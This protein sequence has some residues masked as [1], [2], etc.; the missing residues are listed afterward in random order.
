MVRPTIDEQLHALQR[1]LSEVV[2]PE[3]TAKYPSDI[4]QSVIANL[5]EL[6]ANWSRWVGFL[7][8]DNEHLAEV[9]EQAR[10]K[11]SGALSQQIGAALASAP[12]DPYDYGAV[13]RHN[14]AL[15]AAVAAV[16]QDARTDAN[17][18]DDAMNI[19]RHLKEGIRRR[20]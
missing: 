20:V 2:A 11:V 19:H 1:I 18:T 9:L 16:I 14:E 6:E 4:L 12:T 3:V 15:R 5:G 7:A 13:C 17:L 8:W 10:P